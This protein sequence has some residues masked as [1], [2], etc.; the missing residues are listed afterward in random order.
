M[1][2]I[3]GCNDLD[4]H[5]G[6]D[7]ICGVHHK[8]EKRTVASQREDPSGSSCSPTQ[9]RCRGRVVA[10]GVGQTPGYHRRH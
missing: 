10:Q 2:V 3:A 1:D 6:A 4:S 5:R 9:L 8:T 7:A